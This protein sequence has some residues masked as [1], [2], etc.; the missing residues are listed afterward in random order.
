MVGK[1]IATSMYPF[2]YCMTS[3]PDFPK[4][5]HYTLESLC[6]LYNQ[7]MAD[8]ANLKKAKKYTNVVHPIRVSISFSECEKL[9]S[10]VQTI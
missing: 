4:A 5:D 8:G 1:Q 7:W 6:R 3:S 10:T 2:P 9:E